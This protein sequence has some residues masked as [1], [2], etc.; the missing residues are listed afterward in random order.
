MT[1]QFVIRQGRRYLRLD[2]F[3]PHGG[4]RYMKFLAHRNNLEP[5]MRARRW[6]RQVAR[7]AVKT[8]A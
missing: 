5:A 3:D 8:S 6:A 4:S 2:Q 7:Q 1:P